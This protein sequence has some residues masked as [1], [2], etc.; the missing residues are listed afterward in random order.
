MEDGNIIYEKRFRK[1]STDDY[2]HLYQEA[3]KA[4]ASYQR[5]DPATFCKNLI[6]NTIRV[7]M[8]DRIENC[9]FF[10]AMAKDTAETNEIDTLIIEYEDRYIAEFHISCDSTNFGLKELID[11]AD[12]ISFGC[13]G[14]HA[15]VSVIYYTHATYRSGH[16]V[17]PEEESYFT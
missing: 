5:P 8:P 2:E 6:E 9:G 7:I 17:T 13:D 16:R 15:I 12:D 4:V 14:D 11:F 10:I 3:D 1:L